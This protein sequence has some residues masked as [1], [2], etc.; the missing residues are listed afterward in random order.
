VK[1]IIHI[2]IIHL[3][4]NAKL[5]ELKAVW[6]QTAHQAEQADAVAHAAHCKASEA[7]QKSVD[8]FESLKKRKLV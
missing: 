8:F 5:E 6:E 2:E 1:I 4:E 7:K 3:G